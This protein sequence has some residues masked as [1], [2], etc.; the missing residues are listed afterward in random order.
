[1]KNKHHLYYLLGLTYLGMISSCQAESGFVTTTESMTCGKGKFVIESTCKKSAKAMSLNQCKLQT[2]KV[3]GGREIKLPELTKEDTDSI[4]KS[5]GA[6]KNLY[7]TQWGCAHSRGQDLAVLYYSI[8]GGSAPYS[9]AWAKY[10]STG[11]LVGKENSLDPKTLEALEET[12]KDV[13]SI[14]PE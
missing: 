10:D 7:V 6:V 1:M 3:E 9:E 2:L 8:G 14:M 11:K 12:M 4:V 13:R 5:G